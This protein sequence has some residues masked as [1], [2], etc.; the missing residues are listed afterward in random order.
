MGVRFKKSVKIMP[1]VRINISKSGISTTVGPKGASINIGEKGTYFNT[2]I[3]GTGIYMREKISGG[4]AKT[5]QATPGKANKGYDPEF[6]QRYELYKPITIKIDSSGKIQILDKNN[7]VITDEYFLTKM[8]ATSAYKVQK[9]QLVSQWREKSEEVY[10]KSQNTLAELVNIHHYSFPVKS[11]ED[12]EHELAYITQKH[13]EM[14]SF[15]QEEPSRHEIE[16]SLTSYA[17]LHVTSKAF[18]RIKKL[19]EEYVRDNLETEY[20]KQHIEW[21]KEKR[22]FEEKQQ[23][24]AEKQ[25]ELYAE[26]YRKACDVL[27]EKIAGSEDYVKEHL[28]AWLSSCTLPVE[29]NVDYEYEADTGNMYIDILL[30]SED[31]IPKQQVTRLSNG[32]VKEKEKSRTVIQTEYASMIFGLGICITSGVFDISPAIKRVLTSGFATRRDKEGN[33]VDECIYSIKFERTGF[34]G[35]AIQEQ[36][37]VDFVSRFENRYKA[38]QTWIFKAVIPFDDF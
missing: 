23:K 11:L 14:E 9:E 15:E 12:Y 7:A 33:E 16:Q 34:E 25:N 19:R 6:L 2:G 32:G 1:G 13:Y 28:E 27:K 26:E 5:R 17:N 18:W 31:V 8:K 24:E 36:T 3:P 10:Q 20:Q 4:Q 21:E 29:I 30:P 37:P 22:A 38:T 35:V